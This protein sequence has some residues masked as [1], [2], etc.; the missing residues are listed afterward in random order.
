MAARLVDLGCCPRDGVASSA[1][2]LVAL[3]DQARQRRDA[4]DEHAAV[5]HG[6]AGPGGLGTSAL[7]CRGSGLDGVAVLLHTG[8]LLGG[9]LGASLQCGQCVAPVGELGHEPV[10]PLGGAAH[11]CQ[12]CFCLIK[13]GPGCCDT[14]VGLLQR[15]AL[16]AGVGP[17][18]GRGLVHA[19]HERPVVGQRRCAGPGSVEGSSQG[20]GR[21]QVGLADVMA[22]L[23]AQR[24]PQLLVDGLVEDLA[25]AVVGC[26]ADQ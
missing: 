4:L 23:D 24:R 3:V 18:L 7:E 14:V 19:V 25:H 26:V 9:L 1:H 20:A 5:C 16:T 13:A 11:R 21:G 10:V 2:A 8:E 22:L 6:V 15:L 17:E 12:R